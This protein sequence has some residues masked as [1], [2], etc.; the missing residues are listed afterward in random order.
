[1]L[2]TTT[3]QEWDE[4][5]LISKLNCS[6]FFI[7]SQRIFSTFNFNSAAATLSNMSSK[8]AT[9]WIPEKVLKFSKRF[10]SVFKFYTTTKWFTEIWSRRIFFFLSTKVPLKL[11]TWASSLWKVKKGESWRKRAADFSDQKQE[12]N[13]ASA[14]THVNSI[15]EGSIHTG[16]IGT[17]LYMAPELREGLPYSYP[18]DIYALGVILLELFEIFSTQ[19]ERVTVILRASEGILP[20]SI[21]D[22]YSG[23]LKTFWPAKL[24]SF[25]RCCANF[26]HARWWTPSTSQNRPDPWPV[27]R[28]PA[29][30]YINYKIHSS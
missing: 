30:F 5:S 13:K 10:V 19:Q 4:S 14:I 29:D 20:L 18:I 9:A 25:R 3:I 15:L 26:K 8:S 11:A 17:R 2:I 7:P 24:R 27:P 6:V 28:T 23:N 1:M 12:N 21:R 16:G 22:N